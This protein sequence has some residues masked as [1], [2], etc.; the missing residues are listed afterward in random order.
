[1]VYERVH[2]F[3][4][5][6]ALKRIYV[7]TE[8]TQR[9]SKKVSV[10]PSEVCDFSADNVRNINQ[11]SDFYDMNTKTPFH[12]VKLMGFTQKYKNKRSSL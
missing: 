7:E 11:K 12:W 6:R 3:P 2:F 1:M 10:R 5:L 8:N 9:Y 4:P